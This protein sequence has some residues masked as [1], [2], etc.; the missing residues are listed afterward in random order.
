M[1]YRATDLIIAL[2]LEPHPE[3]GYYRRIYTSSLAVEPMDGRPRRAA[4]TTIY[5]LLVKGQVS[6]W[7][8][9][10]SDEAWHFLEGEPLEMFQADPELQQIGTT[11][12]GPYAEN[13]NPVDVVPAGYWQ[14]AR[15]TGAYALVAC[16]V[17]PGFD[18]SDFE[19]MRD[20]PE[21]AAA[22]KRKHPEFGIFL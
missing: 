8:R 6:A 16:T 15:P 17:G 18:Y 21:R 20:H 7:H 14:A 11:I 10:A 19:L 13:I 4:L 5:Y 9:V 3:G 2:A 22:L 12:L 1:P